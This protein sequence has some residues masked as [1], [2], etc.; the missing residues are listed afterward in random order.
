M[1]MKRALALE[2]GLKVEAPCH[3]AYLFEDR[4]Q[5]MVPSWP[6]ALAP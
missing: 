5:S 6:G 3:R 4:R 2:Q 1:N